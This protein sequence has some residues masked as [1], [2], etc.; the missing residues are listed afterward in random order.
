LARTLFGVEQLAVSKRPQAPGG[1]ALRPVAGGGRVRAPRLLELHV[2]LYGLHA[3][4]GARHPG[5]ARTER[6]PSLLESVWNL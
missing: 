3:I 5:A 2:V 1:R 4:D 6:S